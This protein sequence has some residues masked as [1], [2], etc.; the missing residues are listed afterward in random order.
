MKQFNCC[1]YYIY[2]PFPKHTHHLLFV[3]HVAPK[4]WTWHSSNKDCYL[5]DNAAQAD[6]EPY[7]GIV[8]TKLVYV[9]QVYISEGERLREL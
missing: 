7:D 4:A 5:K 2:V 3:H 1:A 8:Y 9:C 6:P